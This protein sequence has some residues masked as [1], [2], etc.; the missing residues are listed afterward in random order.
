MKYLVT[1]YAS[2]AMRLRID[3]QYLPFPKLLPKSWASFHDASQQRHHRKP[4][5]VVG[6]M[7][8][9]ALETKRLF[10]HATV[11]P[12]GALFS[13]FVHVTSYVVLR[14]SDGKD[15][16]LPAERATRSAC[17]IYLCARSARAFADFF[18]KC[19]RFGIPAI[20]CRRRLGQYTCYVM[21]KS[22]SHFKA[23]HIMKHER[24]AGMQGDSVHL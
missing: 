23:F 3:W 16:E 4:E 22:G 21:Y 2:N 10:L 5:D 7:F 1:G 9:L 15:K 6:H 20:P 13:P 17:K 19:S 18:V 14:I 24:M 8:F 12:T 11:S